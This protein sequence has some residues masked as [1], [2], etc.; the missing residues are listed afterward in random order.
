M[1]IR[2]RKTTCKYNKDH[3]CLAKSILVDRKVLCSTYQLSEALKGKNRQQGLLDKAEDY[4][5]RMFEKPPKNAPMRNRKKI[6][7]SCKADCLFNNNGICRANG[8]T[9]NDVN[10]PI[11]MGYLPK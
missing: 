6:E 2:C 9:V 8:I 7:I 3:T 4:S 5:K 1:D 10:Y 11:C